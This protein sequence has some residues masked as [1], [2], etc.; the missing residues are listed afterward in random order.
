MFV[1]VEYAFSIDI[2]SLSI[3][4]SKPGVTAISVAVAVAFFA[5]DFNFLVA[6]SPDIAANNANAA[7]RYGTTR[8]CGISK[9]YQ[10]LVDET[11]AISPIPLNNHILEIYL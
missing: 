1:S 4:S 2:S 3:V 9:R 11:A 8:I 6:I 5:L 7:M 10:A